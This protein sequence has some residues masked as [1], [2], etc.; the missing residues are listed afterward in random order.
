MD[1]K[2][3][4]LL[5]RSLL[6]RLKA[7]AGSGRPVF[8]GLISPEEREALAWS[9]TAIAGP[10]TPAVDA[11][12]GSDRTQ[13]ETPQEAL[14][15]TGPQ[16]VEVKLD[17]TCLNRKEASDPEYILCLDF[18]TAKSKAFVASTD[19]EAPKLLELALGKRDG[20]RAVYAV[21]SSVWIDDNGLMFAG[22]QA[23]K[24]GIL[25][26]QSGAGGRR[27][28]DS[29]KQELSQIQSAHDV[30]SK[31][32]EPDLNPSGVR[33]TY[34]HAITFYLS[35]LTDLVCCE[36]AAQKLSRYVKRRF[37]LP[38]WRPEQRRWASRMLA[39]RLARA[40]VLADTFRGRWA[41]GIPA[42]DF[43]K[44]FDLVVGKEAQLHWLLDENP[45]VD[46]AFPA[47]W[48]GLLEPLAAGS[49]RIWND[50]ATRDLTL[51]VDVGAGTTDFSV[52][53]VV[54]NG[55]KRLAVPVEPCG[56]AIRMAGDS[57]DSCLVTELA[58]LS[59]QSARVVR[60]PTE[61]EWEGA[62]RGKGGR[63]YAWGGTF[64]ATHANTFEAHV[65]ATTPIG[66]FPAGRTPEGEG[67]GGG[68]CNLTGNVWEWTS[69]ES[70]AYPYREADGRENAER[71]GEVGRV[72]RGGSWNFDQDDARASSRY[73]LVP[74]DRFDYV[75]FRVVCVSPIVNR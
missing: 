50:K 7:D 52:F 35:Y 32:L 4:V 24:L 9:V 54:Q 21:S 74:G 55:G 41:D 13:S 57:L 63:R 48:G 75:G 51:V 61:A 71:S 64:R 49:G 27:R 34:D 59:V 72:L 19:D 26:A 69:S 18:G 5:V 65:R 58:W 73:D 8:G 44:A 15:A 68:V 62:A 28:L 29:L 6:A 22:S 25:R 70:K 1:S 40:Q 39:E 42:A 36:L 37:T 38:W 20:D 16:S 53:W 60:L 12:P 17:E 30:S 23:I 66:V 3:A 33:L 56:T 67:G 46:E 45:D 47:R 14:A 31:L 2:T 11:L 43:K 10:E